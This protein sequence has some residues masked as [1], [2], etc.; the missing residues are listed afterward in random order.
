MVWLAGDK[1]QVADAFGR[2]ATTRGLLGRPTLTPD[3]A[4]K[5]LAGKG[6]PDHG[7]RTVLDLEA[8]G[9]EPAGNPLERGPIKRRSRFAGGEE[10]RVGP[11]IREEQRKR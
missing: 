7:I 10:K 8:E 6:A 11:I 2:G 1:K 3:A 4:K 9:R 5:L